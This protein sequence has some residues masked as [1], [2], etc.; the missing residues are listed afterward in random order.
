MDDLNVRDIE[1]KKRAGVGQR[2]IDIGFGDRHTG[3]ETPLNGLE[4]RAGVVVAAG[5][6]D[7]VIR[8]IQRIQYQIEAFFIAQFRTSRLGR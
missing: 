8:F 4:K 3:I 5:N 7:M 6:N 1:A 2:Q